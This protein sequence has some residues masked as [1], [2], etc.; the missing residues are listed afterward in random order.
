MT[1]LS[2]LWTKYRHSALTP[3]QSVLEAAILPAPLQHTIAPLW[4]ETA[5]IQSIPSNLANFTRPSSEG[6]PAIR[7]TCFLEREGG[8]GNETKSG[9][10]VRILDVSVQYLLMYFEPVEIV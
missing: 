5:P 4:H 6:L 1:A 2:H 7:K 3:L 10:G 8:F 9:A